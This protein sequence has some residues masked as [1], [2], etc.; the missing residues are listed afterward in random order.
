MFAQEAP[1]P[2]FSLSFS[3]FCFLPKFDPRRLAGNHTLFIYHISV[4][5]ITLYVCCSG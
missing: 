1:E 5:L 4:N 2:N 3:S